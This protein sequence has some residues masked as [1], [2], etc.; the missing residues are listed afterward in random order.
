MKTI[1]I[2]L[3]VT[4]VA[5]CEPGYL[6]VTGDEGCV[7]CYKTCDLSR[8]WAVSG[9]EMVNCVAA[10]GQRLVTGT[11]AGHLDIRDRDTG[12]LEASLEGHDRGCGISGLAVGHLGLWSSCFDCKLRLWAE[13][14]DCLCV[15][16]GHTNPVR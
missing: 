2:S 3:A 15:L 12:Q 14:G 10:W 6:I 1:V 11:D 8:V 16:V 4:D 13:A 5:F 9:G 7:T